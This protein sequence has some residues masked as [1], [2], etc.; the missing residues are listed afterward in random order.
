MKKLSLLLLII[1]LL[2]SCS[3]ELIPKALAM[4]TQKIVSHVEVKTDDVFS[5]IQYNIDLVTDLKE[6]VESGRING[7]QLSIDDAIRD[8][9]KVSDSYSNL[10][11]QHDSIRKQLL[12]KIADVDRLREMV[13]DEISVLS[14]RRSDYEQQLSSVKDSNPEIARTRKEAL[15]QSIKYVDSQIELWSEFRGLEDD[16]IIQ[17]S[18]VQETIDTFLN[19]IDSSAILF[20]E[21][22]NLLT[23]QRD[24]NN[25]M[26]LFTQDIPRMEQLT[27]DMERSWESLDYL[28][29]ALTSISIE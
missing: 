3:T 18:T 9:K 22:L 26:S 6:K 27:Q 11:Q 17:M 5:E 14:L 16:I 7:N 2:T 23:L 4:E 12:H 28:V 21:G 19:V 1:P 24:I 8:I 10:S 25:A 20:K 15:A 29:N 13:S